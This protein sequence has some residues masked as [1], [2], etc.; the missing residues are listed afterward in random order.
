MK[1]LLPLAILTLFLA[2]CSL[3]ADVTPPPGYKTPI[4]Q[5]TEPPL[6]GPLFPAEPPSPARGALIYATECA[7]CHGETGLGDGPNAS[8]LRDQNIQVPPLG[9]PDFA[10]LASPERWYT[11]VTQ[12]NLKRFMPPFRSLTDAQRWDVVAYALSLSST[13]AD[14]DA[15]KTLY[16]ANCTKCHTDGEVVFTDQERMS[17]LTNAVIAETI[18]NGKGK[19]EAF[20]KLSETELAQ[21]TAYVRSLS[22]DNTTVAAPQ[23][24]TA[25]AAA[26]GTPLAPGEI[27]TGT[28]LITGTV[29]NSGGIV[30]PAGLTV[31]LYAFEQTDTHPLLAFTMTTQ[32]SAGGGFSFVDVPWKVD[33][34]LGAAVEYQNV[35]YGS[36]AASIT[37]NETT[38]GLSIAVYDVTQDIAGLAVDRHHIIFTFDT[39]GQVSVMEMYSIS[40]SGGKTVAANAPGEAVVN[41]PL[42]AGAE[43]LTLQGGGLGDRFIEAA[44]GFADTEPVYPG[45]GSY[46]VSFQYTLP[47]SEKLDFSQGVNLNTSALTVLVPD[48]GLQVAGEKL[49][50]GG[51]FQGMP[52]RRY[53]ATDL[54]PND[55]VTFSISGQPATTSSGT[56][57]ADETHAN[58]RR[59]LSIGLGALGAVLIAI[60]GWFYLR[61]RK[62]ATETADEETPSIEAES[63]LQDADTLMDAIIALDDQYR[64][65][66]IPEDAYLR[67]REELKALLAKKMGA[68]GRGS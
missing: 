55:V 54:T 31:T 43:N 16:E 17:K 48:V 19:M 59:D 65:G 51:V 42:P 26:S 33:Q 61:T 44:G 22:F 63:A 13:P 3:A 68:G 24:T 50:D 64:T 23:A 47:Y 40:N 66:Q 49:V 25:P 36:Q 15:G 8:Q 32:T 38:V 62:A 4:P 5:P 56:V 11:T 18:A 53:D 46:Q 67:R 21:L 28:G 34:M 14:L 10:R 20:S 37:G 9:L 60:G 30:I 1:R 45:S 35:L 12:G 41:F 2:A 39:P 27:F 29:S 57:P 58:A 52:Y 6:E 7:P